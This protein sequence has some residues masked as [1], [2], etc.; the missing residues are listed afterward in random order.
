MDDMD[1]QNGCLHYTPQKNKALRRHEDG[2]VGFSRALADWGPEDEAAEV[3]MVCSRGD[4]LVHH[5]LTVHRAGLNTTADRHRR[6]IGFG[7][8]SVNVVSSPRC[9]LAAK[10]V[11]C[12]DAYT[13]CQQEMGPEIVN[14]GIVVGGKLVRGLYN[15]SEEEGEGFDQRFAGMSSAELLQAIRTW[16]LAE[17]EPG[18]F[19]AMDA[20]ELRQWLREHAPL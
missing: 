5:C 6:T 8:R 10:F 4:V 15:D 2:V 13:A 16:G 17:P 14:K 20:E 7:Y 9:H 12:P 1:E 11:L 18:A 3:P 19:G